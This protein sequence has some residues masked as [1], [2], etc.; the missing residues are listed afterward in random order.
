MLIGKP[1]ILC[2]DAFSFRDIWGELSTRRVELDLIPI[3]ENCC[4]AKSEKM[5]TADQEKCKQNRI[6]SRQRDKESMLVH[7]DLTNWGSV[8]NTLDEYAGDLKLP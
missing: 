1:W 5:R 6:D 4:D 3:T 7:Q 8:H 2:T